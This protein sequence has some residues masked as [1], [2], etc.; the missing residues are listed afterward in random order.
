[1]RVED[2]ARRAGE[3]WLRRN[4][5]AG[6]QWQNPEYAKATAGAGLTN[7]VARR[8]GISAA[9]PDRTR[10]SFRWALPEPRIQHSNVEI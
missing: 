4:D 8:L 6:L 3:I 2:P 9:A 10:R 7:P 1:M 5:V